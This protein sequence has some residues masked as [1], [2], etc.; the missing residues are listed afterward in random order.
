MNEITRSTSGRVAHPNVMLFDVRV[1]PLTFRAAEEIRLW[2]PHPFA[3]L[4]RVGASAG[5]LLN[6]HAD[7]KREE[8]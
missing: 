5:M 1:G 3:F 4:R 8:P 7:F 2:V 6:C